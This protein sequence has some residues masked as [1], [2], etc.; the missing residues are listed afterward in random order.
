MVSHGRSIRRKPP[1]KQQ[2]LTG[3]GWYRPEQWQR[4]REVSVDADKLEE[5]HAEWLEIA[6][7][8][9]SDLQ[10]QGV[11]LVKVDMDVEELLTWCHEQRLPVDGKARAR[12]TAHKLE[13]TGGMQSEPSHDS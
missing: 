11:S 9:F 10:R 1:D 7:K 6:R 3:I 2:P 4:L 13:Q 12:F 5:T 8:T